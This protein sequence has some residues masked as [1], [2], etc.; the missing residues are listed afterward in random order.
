MNKINAIYILLCLYFSPCCLSQ[1]ENCNFLPHPAPD[2]TT[3][4][5]NVTNPVCSQ[6]KA[7]SMQ[8]VT[9]GADKRQQAKWKI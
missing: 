6:E 2:T 1:S 8:I 9:F 7:K 3:L 5:Q 4:S